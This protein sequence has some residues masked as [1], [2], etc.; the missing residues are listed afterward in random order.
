MFENIIK[1]LVNSDIKDIS[2]ISRIGERVF[3]AVLA[4]GNLNDS[5]TAIKIALVEFSKYA[6]GDIL[7]D[8]EKIIRKEFEPLNGNRLIKKKA[9]LLKEI[10]ETEVKAVFNKKRTRI[11][12]IRL[13]EEEYERISYEANKQGL[14]ISE[15]IRR[16]LGLTK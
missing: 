5:E 16:K 15:Y 8:F 2:T 7:R 10:W 11:I 6:G 13:S 3:D 14:T 12:G 4:S 1:K 9:K